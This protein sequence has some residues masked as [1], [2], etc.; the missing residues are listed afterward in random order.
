M[1]KIL[2]ERTI[3]LGER[4]GTVTKERRHDEEEMEIQKSMTSI[5][6]DFQGHFGLY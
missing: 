5:W 1:Y 4:A 6:I 2:W 3:C